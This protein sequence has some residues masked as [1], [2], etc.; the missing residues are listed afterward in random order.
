VLCTDHAV[1]FKLWS[2]VAWSC[3]YELGDK[4]RKSFDV[5][6]SRESSLEMR[7]L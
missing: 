5:E 1:L 6:T 2:L 7:R 3:G 4:G